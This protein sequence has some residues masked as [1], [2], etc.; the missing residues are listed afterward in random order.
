MEPAK[1][2]LALDPGTRTGWC[3]GAP[4]E[5]PQSG[6]VVLRQPKED[7]SILCHN[8]GAFFR[9]ICRDREPDLV[10]W[11]APMT[12]E[13]WFQLCQ[14]IGRPQNGPSLTIQNGLSMILHAECG[15]KAIQGVEVA[16]QS[17][18]KHFTGRSSWSSGP[19]AGDGRENGKK[20]VIARAKL[21]GILPV[22]SKDDDRADAIAN[23]DYAS[24]LYGRKHA[25]DLVLFDEGRLR[26]A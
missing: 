6:S 16:R 9:D 14:R 4:G 19:G 23:H 25:A 3:R 18:M 24:A 7:L 20:Q 26:H 11:E 22:D 10:V 2:I 5:K 12:P 13:A 21:L 1:F 15:R 17:V 8:I